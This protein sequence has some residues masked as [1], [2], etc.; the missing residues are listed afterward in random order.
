MLDGG[1]EKIKTDRGCDDGCPTCNY[2][3]CYINDCE[4][5]LTKSVIHI[6]TNSDDED[7]LSEQHLFEIFLGNVDTIRKMSEND[8][9]KFIRIEIESVYH[10]AII[11]S[12][13]K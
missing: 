3:Q 9:E 11:R 6:T 4:I 10:G 1:V 2:G 12:F 7:V 13:K 5:T 8:L